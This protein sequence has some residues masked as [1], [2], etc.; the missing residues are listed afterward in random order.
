MIKKIKMQHQY[1]AKALASEWDNTRYYLIDCEAVTPRERIESISNS[2]KIYPNPASNLLNIDF[3]GSIAKVSVSNVAGRIII[4]KSIYK[5][6]ALD[7]SSLQNGIYLISITD[8][9]GKCGTN[10][11]LKID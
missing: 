8:E 10:K 2:S 7:I 5:N 1:I 6:E 4:A 3:T 11:F 9:D